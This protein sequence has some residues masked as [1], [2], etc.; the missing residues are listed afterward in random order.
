MV[1]PVSESTSIFR[2]S[3]SAGKRGG[4]P[5]GPLDEYPAGAGDRV[6]PAGFVQVCGCSEP[7]H[8]GVDQPRGRAARRQVVEVDYAEGGAHDLGGIDP[9]GGRDRLDERRLAGPEIPFEGHERPLRQGH[10]QRPGDGR[11]FRLVGDPDGAGESLVRNRR[12]GG[13]P[14]AQAASD[15]LADQ[16]RRFHS[17]P[18]RRR[19]S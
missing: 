1:R 18:R 3:R 4:N 17:P 8:V 16:S 15:S 9:D 14:G 11:K 2:S 13:I 6:I 12:H 10:R 7:V 5:S 19:R